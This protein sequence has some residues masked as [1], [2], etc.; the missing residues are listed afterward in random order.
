MISLVIKH[1]AVKLELLIL[2][3]PQIDFLNFYVVRELKQ[4]MNSSKG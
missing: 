1:I 4:T 3:D 2:S